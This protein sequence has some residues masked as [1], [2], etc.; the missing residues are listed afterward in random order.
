M[1]TKAVIA[2]MLAPLVVAAE[3]IE[4]SSDTPNENPHVHSDIDAETQ[5]TE[6]NPISAFGFQSEDSFQVFIEPQLPRFRV[7]GVPWG[8]YRVMADNRPLSSLRKPEFEAERP[9]PMYSDCENAKALFYMLAGLKLLPQH[10]AGILQTALDGKTQVIGGG[11]HSS[12][13]LFNSKQL[14]G[15]GMTYRPLDC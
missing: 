10:L 6:A 7:V 5:T 3:V 12:M 8:N 13:R 4:A 15:I 1:R 2:G 14:A 9:Q 11:H